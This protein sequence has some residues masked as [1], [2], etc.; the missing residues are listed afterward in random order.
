MTTAQAT[1]TSGL[2]ARVSLDRDST[3]NVTTLLLMFRLFL[4]DVKLLRQRSPNYSCS[5]C[6]SLQKGWIS[7]ST[8]LW[9]KQDKLEPYDSRRI[10]FSGIQPTG[11]PHLGNYLGALRQWVKIQNEAS[12]D[13]TLIYSI[14]DLHAITIKQNR[15]YLEKWRRETLIS[16]LSV[17]LD[18][19]RS[20][21]FF[22]S[23]V[24][25]SQNPAA[26]VLSV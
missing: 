9:K 7:Y 3:A 11:V 8:S 19:E 25:H 4:R 12:Q 23:D 26:A 24:G 21:I 15:D 6:N 5:H 22:Q 20:I 2:S 14:V 1:A 17:G 13:T 16:L 18:P 10:I